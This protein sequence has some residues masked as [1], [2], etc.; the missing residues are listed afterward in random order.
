MLVYK[1]FRANEWAAFQAEGTTLGAPVDMADGF[2]HFSTGLQLPETLRRHF[3][4]EVDLHLA[5]INAWAAGE[6]LRWEASRGGDLFPHL[7]RPLAWQEIAWS[8]PL[9]SSDVFLNGAEEKA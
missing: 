8:C 5:A 9:G 4:G 3:P 7:Y 2:I 6:H 1:V